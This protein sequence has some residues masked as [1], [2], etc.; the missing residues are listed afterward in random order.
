MSGELNPWLFM[1]INMTI[2]FSVLISLW[3][4]MVIIHAI[5]PTKAKKNLL[6]R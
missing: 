4:L 5:D 1:A 2:V 3:V 6:S